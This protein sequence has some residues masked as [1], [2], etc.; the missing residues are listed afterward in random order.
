MDILISVLSS[1]VHLVGIFLYKLYRILRA[2]VI[3]TLWCPTRYTDLWVYSGIRLMATGIKY[4]QERPREIKKY[5]I[6][7]WSFFVILI[8]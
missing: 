2:G 1:Y 7:R 5:S 8:H 4:D 3:V 6:E